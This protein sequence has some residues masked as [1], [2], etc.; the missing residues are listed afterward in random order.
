MLMYVQEIL[1]EIERLIE[2]A[3]KMP[4]NSIFWTLSDHPKQ[5][6]PR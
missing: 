1:A 4:K 2:Y 3:E 6:F 5:I